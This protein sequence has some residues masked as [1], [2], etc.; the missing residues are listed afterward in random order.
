MGCVVCDVWFVVCQAGQAM[1]A[2]AGVL[3]LG[4][5]VCVST[6]T[7]TSIYVYINTCAR[8][9]SPTLTLT[10]THTH[11]HACIYTL[12]HMCT[13]TH[14]HSLAGRLSLEH[15]EIAS[16]A[17]R[18]WGGKAVA[19]LLFRATR[20]SLAGEPSWLMRQRPFANMVIF[21]VFL[22]KY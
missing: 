1:M 7:C 17:R 19:W 20:Q 11:A 4:V 3:L 16:R 10:L 13:L 8:A 2:S 12:V 15:P 21:F 18:S 5:C 9:L 22:Q 14:T 6:Y